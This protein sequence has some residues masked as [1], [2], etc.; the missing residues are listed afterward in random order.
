MIISYDTS[1][2][3]FLPKGGIVPGL[4]LLKKIRYVRGEEV[5]RFEPRKP[6]D[7]TLGR[8]WEFLLAENVVKKTRP[9]FSRLWP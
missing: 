2:S 3:H 6:E 7:K 1:L 9:W 8:S 5:L 4:D